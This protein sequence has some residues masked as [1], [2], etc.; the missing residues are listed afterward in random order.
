MDDLRTQPEVVGGSFVESFGAVTLAA[1][2]FPIFSCP[3]P[4]LS[5]MLLD[6]GERKTPTTS[7][8]AAV[9]A[10][11]RPSGLPSPPN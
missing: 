6:V 1:S 9:L 3:A 10:E 4:A 11:G 5:G 8:F 2:Y 7:A